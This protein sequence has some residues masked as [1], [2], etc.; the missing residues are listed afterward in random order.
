MQIKKRN[1]SFPFQID[2]RISNF[3]IF[4]ISNH[5]LVKCVLAK[6]L[7]DRLVIRS[8]PN[9]FF[10]NFFYVGNQGLCLSRFSVLR[11]FIRILNLNVSE[12]GFFGYRSVVQIGCDFSI[13]KKRM[14]FPIFFFSKCIENPKTIW[15]IDLNGQ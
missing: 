2:Y 9:S 12:P 13:T 8:A 4:H 1:S 10:K 6:V 15:S 3:T 7:F 5:T 11:I 14:L